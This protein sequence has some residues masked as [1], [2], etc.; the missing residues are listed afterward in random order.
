MNFLSNQI[1]LIAEE[2]F[3]LIIIFNIEKMIEKYHFVLPNEITD[4]IVNR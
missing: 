4:S 1:A 2:K 3:F